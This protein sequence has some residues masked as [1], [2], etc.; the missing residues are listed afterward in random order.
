MM[1]LRLCFS[2]CFA[3]RHSNVTYARNM[4]RNNVCLKTLD[5]HLWGNCFPSHELEP[6]YV[7]KSTSTKQIKC[8]RKKE[9]QKIYKTLIF[10]S[11]VEQN[12]LHTWSNQHRAVIREKNKHLLSQ[13][14]AHGCIFVKKFTY[15]SSSYKHHWK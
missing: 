2:V 11:C 7:G 9:V 6:C 5:K 8:S 15:Y 4:R 14:I 12:H 13:I 1:I 10:K 3:A